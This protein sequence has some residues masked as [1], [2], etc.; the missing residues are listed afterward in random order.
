MVMRRVAQIII[1]AVLSLW[2]LP[3]TICADEIRFEVTLDRDMISLGDSTQLNLA[4]YGTQDI[5]APELPEMEGFETRYVGPSSSVSIINRKV[6]L[7]VTHVYTIIPL[8]EGTFT[9]GPFMYDYEGKEYKADPVTIEVVSSQARVK[10]PRETR[11]LSRPRSQEEDISGRIYLSMQ[12]PRDT[13]YV[14]EIIPLTVK[15]HINRMALKNVEYPKIPHEGFSIGKFEQPRQYR[16]RDFNDNVLDV[17]EFQ[18]NL[19]GTRPG[20]FELGPAS[21]NATRIIRRSSRRGYGSGFDDFFED[22][23]F[24][25]FFGRYETRPIKL[26]SKDVPITVLPFPEEGKPD[27]F[28]GTIG[29]FGFE[30][31]AEP[32]E[33]QAGDPITLTMRVTGN[34]NFDTVTA[35]V[36][37]NTEG[38]KVY[39]P[40]VIEEK[41][42]EKVFEQVIIPTSDS[43]TEIP[44]IS[45]S[46]F[47]PSRKIYQVISRGYIPIN[48]TKPEREEELK[49]VESPRGIPQT[50]RQEKL[51]RDIIYIKESAKKF[52]KRGELLYRNRGFL[53]LHLLPLLLLGS[54]FGL[55]RQHVRLRTDQRYARLT[56][57]PKKARAGLKEASRFLKEKKSQEFCDTVFKTLQEYI[58]D[59]YQVATGG[60]TANV[61]DELLKSKGLKE[62]VLEKLRK[63]FA[64]CDMARY[65][66]SE[67]GKKEMEETLKDL[68]EVIDYMERHR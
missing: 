57:A 51:G 60:I 18:T 62:E 56:R 61:I 6:S 38:F 48:V 68:R 47:N 20:E 32:K 12:I 59:R 25:D 55:H 43:V 28:N 11:R 21:L 5:R 1:I 23:F 16:E 36:M 24:G 66:A 63:T 67:I 3:D 41:R 40:T 53:S 46:Y 34:G 52:N 22:D 14:N 54:L 19:F 7:S 26:N 42:A 17:I 9:L 29:N 37:E 27:T 64:S 39:D 8:E 33:V 45:L 58:G 35:P 50:F 49:I 13:V 10:R 44:K 31:S 2:V 4:F 15:L 30:L 65:A